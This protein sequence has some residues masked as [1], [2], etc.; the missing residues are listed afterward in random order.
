MDL[1]KPE[2]QFARFIHEAG[3]LKRVARSGWWAAG[4]KDPESVADHSF[5]TGIIARFLA[6]LEGADAEKVLTMALFHDI[7]EARI[8]DMHKVAQ[9]YVD[10]DEAQN[11]AATEQAQSLPEPSGLHIADIFAEMTA[12]ETLE[13]RVAKDADHLECLFQAREYLALGHPVEDWIKNARQALHTASAKKIAD[14]A[15]DLA[16]YDW[17]RGLK[18]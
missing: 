4:V 2:I 14:A 8:N 17:W 15:C 3:Q 12:M 6:D 18:I 13:A 11:R 1:N 16:P 10:L 7:P 9:R 5:R